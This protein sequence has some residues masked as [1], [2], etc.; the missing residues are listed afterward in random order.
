ISFVRSLFANP[1]VFILDEATSSL[2]APTGAV[3][4]QGLEELL[5]RRPSFIIDHRLCTVMIAGRVLVVVRGQ[6]IEDWAPVQLIAAGGQF[7]QLYH[8]WQDSLAE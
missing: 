5:G 4:Q 2:D 6:I 7:S 8:A 3:V 1:I